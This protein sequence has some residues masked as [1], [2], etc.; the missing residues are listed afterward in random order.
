MTVTNIYSTWGMLLEVLV[1]NNID[2]LL[3]QNMF[4][5]NYLQQG[6]KGLSH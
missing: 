6:L 2:H 3:F 4:F 1:N 5:N